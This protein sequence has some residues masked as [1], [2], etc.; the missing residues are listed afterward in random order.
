MY[1]SGRRI[2]VLLT[3]GACAG[4]FAVA[5]P[6]AVAAPGANLAFVVNAT[7]DAHDASPGDGICADL[8]GQWWGHI[9]ENQSKHHWASAL[10]SLFSYF[11]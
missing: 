5:V 4:G 3:A 7:T 9:N 8:A 2:L 1:R 10:G 11:T 6:A